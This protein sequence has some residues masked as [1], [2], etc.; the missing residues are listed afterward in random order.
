MDGNAMTRTFNPKLEALALRISNYAKPLAYDVTYADVAEA[1]GVSLRLV[2]AVAKYKGWETR[3]RGTVLADAWTF[4]T[5]GHMSGHIAAAR[6]MA[7][8][9]VAGRIGYAG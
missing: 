8:D 1:L 9:I 7:A 2:I 5:G 3:F 6:N 4:R